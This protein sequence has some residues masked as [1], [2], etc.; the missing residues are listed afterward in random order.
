MYDLNYILNYKIKIKLT[1]CVDHCFTASLLQTKLIN[2]FGNKYILLC[3]IIYWTER[4]YVGEDIVYNHKVYCV[5]SIRWGWFV[6]IL[7]LLLL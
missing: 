2:V 3:Y 6:K 5:I 4:N 1:K 7:S